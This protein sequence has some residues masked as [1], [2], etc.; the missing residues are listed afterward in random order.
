MS[1]QK[2]IWD[3]FQTESINN[4]DDAI[5]RLRYLLKKAKSYLKNKKGNSVKVLNIGIGNGWI[6]K[7]C[8]KF[9][10]EVSAID[11]SEN[12][13]EQLKKTGINALKASI[14]SLPFDNDTFDIVFCSEVFEHLDNNELATG[15][16]EIA[17]IL[18][19]DGILIGTVPYNELLETNKTVCPSCGHV[20]HRWGHQQSFTK[21]K[22][23]KIAE[24]YRFKDIELKVM[25]FPDFSRPALKDK[26]KSSI[27]WILG[28]CSAGIANPNLFFIFKKN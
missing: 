9:G 13:V 14:S 6:E 10:F 3:H 25:A 2:K 4:F 15:L 19:K 1:D 16:K 21:D 11:P 26:I 5:P 18:N 7:A 12:A 24:E 8:F 23:R 28:R 27:R 22:L 20:F 17:R